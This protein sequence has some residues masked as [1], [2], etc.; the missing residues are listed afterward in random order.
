VKTTTSLI[1]VF[2][3]GGF[4][5]SAVDRAVRELPSWRGRAIKRQP[6]A[7]PFAAD[8]RDPAG[9]SAA[10]T[11]ADAVVH[12]AS[13]IGSDPALCDA[14]NVEGARNVA[15]AAR[16]RGLR[17]TYV[18]TAAVYGRE[19][20][21]F[22]REETRQV[23][24]ESTLSKSR[25]TA[26]QIILDHG[27]V[28]IRPHLVVGAGDRWVGP[29]IAALVQVIGGLVG[30]GSARHSVIEV[31][32]LGHLVA[33]IATAPSVPQSTFHA[34]HSAPSTA[35]NITT[36]MWPELDEIASIHLH[37]AQALVSVTPSLSSALRLFSV[38]HVLDS[39]AAQSIS[40]SPQLSSAFTL[41]STAQTW[42]RQFSPLGRGHK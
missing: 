30:G 39:E 16:A 7:S 27:G 37:A 13:Y 38:D 8:I 9:V 23:R 42:Y 22:I 19:P 2:G 31:D 14:I 12:A 32:T 25:A 36:Q 41:S 34:A 40:T 24:P 3:A 33:E 1:A 29:G 26:E 20:Y 18:S 15:Q 21:D 4:I 11:G 5:G 17:V 28:I 6:G 10:L 35:L